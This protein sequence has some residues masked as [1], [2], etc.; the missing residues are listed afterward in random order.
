MC[1]Q[2]LWSYWARSIAGKAAGDD[3]VV[4]LKLGIGS[5]RAHYVSGKQ[6]PIRTRTNHRQANKSYA[7]HMQIIVME[8][9]TTSKGAFTLDTMFCFS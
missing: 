9:V 8:D 3:V 4:L 5:P 2:A 1:G 6:L 7:E